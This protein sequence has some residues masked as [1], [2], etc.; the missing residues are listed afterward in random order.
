MRN[1]A[2]RLN[3]EL[4]RVN[5][6]ALFEFILLAC[7]LYE[8]GTDEKRILCACV[9]VC[10]PVYLDL[11]WWLPASCLLRPP[12]FSQQRQCTSAKGWENMRRTAQRSRGRPGLP[13][14]HSG[15]S[16]EDRHSKYHSS[17]HVIWF[18]FERCTVMSLR[19][20]SFFGPLQ[21]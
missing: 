18:Y 21:F 14:A 9:C 8:A 5:K 16:G 4:G 20:Y 15:L 7:R 17:M 11:N 13:A 6:G 19:Q 2:I 12:S 3:A 10:M 1:R